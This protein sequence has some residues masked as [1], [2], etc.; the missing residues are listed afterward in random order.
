MRLPHS[1]QLGASALFSNASLGAGPAGTAKPIG[2]DSADS[3]GAS[4]FAVAIAWNA[5]AIGATAASATGESAE[6]DLKPGGAVAG[7]ESSREI[8]PAFSLRSAVRN[9]DASQRKM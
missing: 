7:P 8:T 9:F 3:T 4:A 6:A 2:R 5:A 1:W